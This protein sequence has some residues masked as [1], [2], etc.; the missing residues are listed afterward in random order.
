MRIVA[1]KMLNSIADMKR[2][3]RIVTNTVSR[4]LNFSPNC[5]QR[6]NSLLYQQD[7][8]QRLLKDLEVEEKKGQILAALAEAQKRILECI[9]IFVARSTLDPPSNLA[10][11]WKDR[12]SQVM[13]V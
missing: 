1:T 10:S 13:Y 3:G 5:N 11:V 8:L 7:F 12:K 6:I 2:E 9:T 4:V